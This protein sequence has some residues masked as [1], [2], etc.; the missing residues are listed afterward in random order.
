MKNLFKISLVLLIF[1]LLGND[2]LQAQSQKFG[3][4]N[5]QQLILLLPESEVADKELETYQKKLA[6]DFQ[7]KVEVFKVDADKFEKAAYVDKTLSPIEIQEQGAALQ[8][9]QQAL[10][11]EEY[12]L[13][14]KVA[15]KRNELL[16]PILDKIDKAIKEVG[17]EG[18][19]TM[20]FDS[21]GLNVMLYLDDSTDV[22]ALVKAKLGL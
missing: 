11:Q 1:T 7:K 8:Q 13:S 19:Y 4:L 14:N 2:S 18:N 10:G 9:R 17:K 5:S 21:S 16:K 6:E 20:I 22:M 3:Y 15:E 12:G